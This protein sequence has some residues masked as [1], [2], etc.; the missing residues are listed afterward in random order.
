MPKKTP[1]MYE[2]CVEHED[3]TVEV[4]GYAYGDSWVAMALSM[5]DICFDTPEEAKAWWES[6]YGGER[7]EL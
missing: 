6:N 5:G 1:T 2:S 7:D 4:I 3:G